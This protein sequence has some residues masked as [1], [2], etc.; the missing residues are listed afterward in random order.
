VIHI[1]GV[2]NPAVDNPAAHI[3]AADNRA[4]VLRADNSVVV[5]LADKRAVMRPEHIPVWNTVPCTRA[6]T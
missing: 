1:P 6:A 2:D 3:P 5:G 4:M